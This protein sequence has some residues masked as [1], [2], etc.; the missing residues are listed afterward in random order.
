[1]YCKTEWGVE[2]DV[3]VSLKF[4]RFLVQFQGTLGRGH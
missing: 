2:D 1:M 4:S 3:M